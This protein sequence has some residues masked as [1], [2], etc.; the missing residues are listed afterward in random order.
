MTAPVDPG[1]LWMLH[2]MEAY[3]IVTTEKPGRFI[4]LCCD[5][6][7]TQL[8]LNAFNNHKALV[9]AVKG[10]LDVD[11]MAVWTSRVRT[12]RVVLAMLKEREG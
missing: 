8:I 2:D 1:P 9:A 7:H 6:K 4:A 5:A 10:L 12:A 3:T 11:D